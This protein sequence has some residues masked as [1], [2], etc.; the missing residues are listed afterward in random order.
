MEKGVEVL[1]VAQWVDDLGHWNV[2]P[3]WELAGEF[4]W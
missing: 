1:K 2:E 4:G 3:A